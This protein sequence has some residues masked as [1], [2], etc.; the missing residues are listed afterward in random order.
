MVFFLSQENLSRSRLVSEQTNII[1]MLR[2]SDVTLLL[3]SGMRSLKAFEYLW[4]H[5]NQSLCHFYLQKS[6]ESHGVLLKC[7]QLNEEY[8]TYNIEFACR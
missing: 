8:F 7:S 4:L 6:L 1:Y 5:P 3:W 2:L